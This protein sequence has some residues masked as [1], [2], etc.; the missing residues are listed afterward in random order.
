MMESR[1]IPDR[2]ARSLDQAAAF[3]PLFAVER[4]VLARIAAAT[5][6]GRRA[7]PLGAVGEIILSL[8]EP[9]AGG[10]RPAFRAGT[11]PTHAATKLTF[12]SGEV[13]LTL[14]LEPAASGLPVG[15]PMNYRVLGRLS[16]AEDAAG[17]TVSATAPH[18]QAHSVLDGTGFFDLELPSGVHRLEIALARTK[19]VVPVLEV[20]IAPQA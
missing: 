18:S 8:L 5:A 9:A 7:S 10:L 17:S 3:E 2:L 6:P 4:T 19:V 1:H 13:R 15:L 16:G 20:G 14:L 11:N 12:T